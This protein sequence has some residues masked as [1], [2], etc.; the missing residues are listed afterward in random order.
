[1][2]TARG[3]VRT[4][5]FDRIKIKTLAEELGVTSRAVIERCRAAGVP[6][7]NSITKL[8]HKQAALVRA[9]FAN[10]AEAVRDDKMKPSVEGDDER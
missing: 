4:M 3:R 6:A 5:S 9:W 7:Q 2:A 8:T 10:Q 1:M